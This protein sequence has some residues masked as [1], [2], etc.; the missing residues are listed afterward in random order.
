M[1][2]STLQGDPLAGDRQQNPA[3]SLALDWWQPG[4]SC[5]AQYLARAFAQVTY[6]KS[7]RDMFEPR[8]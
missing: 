7:L 6:R 4:F 8:F 2:R 1:A 3:M 5:R